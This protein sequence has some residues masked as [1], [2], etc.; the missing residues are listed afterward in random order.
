MSTD[1]KHVTCMARL[2]HK[3]E[4]TLSVSVNSHASFPGRGHHAVSFRDAIITFTSLSSHNPLVLWLHNRIDSD[5]QTSSSECSL[6][7]GRM[8]GRQPFCREFA[9]RQRVRKS[10]GLVQEEL[11]IRYVLVPNGTFDLIV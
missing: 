10:T 11:A 7:E 6:S 1:I 5:S 2:Q 9:I 3:I 8:Q 4:L